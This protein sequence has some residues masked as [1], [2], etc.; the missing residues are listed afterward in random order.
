M[1]QIH[2][3]Q[4]KLPHRVIVKAPGLLPMYYTFR[5]LTEELGLPPSTLR[6]WLQRGAPHE[7]DARMHVWINGRAF[8]EWVNQMRKR[9]GQKRMG[10]DEAY[11]VR[12]NQAV[13]LINPERRAIAGKLGHLTGQCPQCGSQVQRGVRYG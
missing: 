1:T 12:C 3:P 13:H 9:T 4:I 8:A 2:T 11:C 6:D 5:E 7:R 10:S